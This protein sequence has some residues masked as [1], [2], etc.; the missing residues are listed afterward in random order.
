MADNDSTNTGAGAGDGGNQNQNAGDTANS[1]GDGDRSLKTKDVEAIT[2]TVLANL[3]DPISDMIKTSVGDMKQGISTEITGATKRQVDEAF[4]KLGTKDQTDRGNA[5]SGKP[6]DKGELLGQ[7]VEMPG[8]LSLTVADLA[9]NFVEN[10]KN[11]EQMAQREKVRQDSEKLLTIKTGLQSR[12]VLPE[13][14]D[15]V[16]AGVA[17]KVVFDD[18]GNMIAKEVEFPNPLQNVEPKTLKKDMPVE[19]FLDY[20]VKNNPAIV[21]TQMRQGS[22]GGEGGGA[23][24]DEGEFTAEKAMN[25]PVLYEK[26]MEQDAVGCQ[27]AMKAYEDSIMAPTS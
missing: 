7:S 14:M 3:K 21:E 4:K 24:G 6:I 18:N 23:S 15:L 13:T 27:K 11:Q 20:V 17:A 10:Q 22:G 25:D 8:G 1:G 12:K 2:A 26:W 9:K 19:E 16:A 5:G